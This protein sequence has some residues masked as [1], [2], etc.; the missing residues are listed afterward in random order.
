[1][2]QYLL[3]V[4]HEEPVE[5]D[6]GVPPTEEMQRMFD[7]VGAFNRELETAGAWVFA[8]GLHAPSS[9][10][11]VRMDEDGGVSTTDGPYARTKAHMGG[12]WIIEA[13]DLDTALDWARRGTIA[14]GQPVEVRPFHDV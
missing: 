8:G 3:S 12:F 14:C 11:V 9:A 2:A 5:F 4:W 1:M 10:T 13:P 6:P 7:Q